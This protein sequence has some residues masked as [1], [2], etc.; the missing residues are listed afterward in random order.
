MKVSVINAQR[1]C[2]VNL[3]TVKRLAAFLLGK[4]SKKGRIRWGEISI[5][6]TDDARI[7]KINAAS[8]G[9]DYPTDVISFNYSALPG[10]EP[11]VNNGELVISVEHARRVGQTHQGENHELALYL[12]HGCDHLSGEEDDTP[13]HRRRMR[14]RELRWLREGKGK[15]LSL[16]L[17]QQD[18]R[19]KT[20][21]LIHTNSH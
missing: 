13:P 3:D 12:A 17:I 2:R 1:Q 6:L 4:A 20:S 10:E 7:R 14:R 19:K 5:I 16:N 11:D 21:P 8:L 15:G 18:H 9:H